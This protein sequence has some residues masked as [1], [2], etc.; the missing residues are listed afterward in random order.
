MWARVDLQA[1]DGHRD[2]V[3]ASPRAFIVDHEVLTEDAPASADPST[4]DS[5]VAAEESSEDT[6]RTSERAIDASLRDSDRDLILRALDECKG[7]VSK[8]ARKL[9]VSRGLIYRR[10]NSD[11]SASS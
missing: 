3:A 2:L 11:Q 9:K 8:A 1:R 5:V 10:M 4:A 6:D 7:N